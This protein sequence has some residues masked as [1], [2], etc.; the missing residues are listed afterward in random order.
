MMPLRRPCHSCSASQHTLHTPV[1]ESAPKAILRVPSPSTLPFSLPRVIAFRH[2]FA[3]LAFLRYKLMQSS[4]PAFCP[5]NGQQ[6][7][8]AG[9]HA[10]CRLLCQRYNWV[11]IGG[12]QWALAGRPCGG[13]VRLQRIGAAAAGQPHVRCC[14]GHAHLPGMRPKLSYLQ[15][16]PGSALAAAC[17]RVLATAF[18]LIFRLHAT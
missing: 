13:N 11:N 2:S 18:D 5:P 6:V 17:F 9:L 14:C 16:L 8:S 3:L 7:L 15:A 10:C 12:A 1:Y 4:V